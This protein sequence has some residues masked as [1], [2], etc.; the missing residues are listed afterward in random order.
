MNKQQVEKAI[1]ELKKGKKRNFSQSYDLII[2]LKAI[3]PKS[4]SVDLFV[5][6]PHPKPK[7]S[8]VA[9]FVGQQLVTQSEKLCD[10]AIKEADFPKYQD[11]IK[12]VHLCFMADPF[13]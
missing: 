7:K 3:N 10:L 9:A 12:F 2:N 11:K 6:L 13:M 4:D 5:T 1:A 8:K